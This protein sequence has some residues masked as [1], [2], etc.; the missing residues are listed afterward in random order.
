MNL[1]SLFSKS[2]INN[3]NDSLY[4]LLIQRKD[5]IAY[6]EFIRGK[7]NVYEEDYICKL[8]RGM[9]QKEQQQ[10]ISL[11]FDELWKPREAMATI[12]TPKKKSKK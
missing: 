11:T 12:E 1:S 7:Y 9:T 5:S 6:V 2:H 8:L 4:F 3:R 10:I